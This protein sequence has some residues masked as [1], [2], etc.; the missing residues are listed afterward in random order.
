MTELFR[1]R[2]ERD[3]LAQANKVSEE[4]GIAPGE[5]VRVFFKQLVKRRA[6]PFP[7]QADELEDEIFTSAKRRNALA[8]EF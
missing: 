8:D 6:V 3:L 5:L 7:L 2:I 1:V 4:I